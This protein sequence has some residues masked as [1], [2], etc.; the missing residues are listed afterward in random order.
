[1]GSYVLRLHHPGRR[2]VVYPVLIRRCAA[3]E[4]TV[5]LRTDEEIGPEFV[6]VPGGPFRYGRGRLHQVLTR[7]ERILS[8][9][10]CAVQARPVTYADYARFLE[11]V[12]REGGRAAVEARMPS[13]P[14]EGPHMERGPDGEYRVREGLPLPPAH[15]ANLGLHGPAYADRL[16]VFG[17]S[18]HDAR[19]YCAWRTRETGREW[20]LPTEAEWEK[21]ARG[22]DGR[23]YPWGD[24]DDRSL[25]KWGDSRP[26]PAFPE[27]VGAFPTATSVY[28][29]VDAAG[30]SWDWTDT[31]HD[32]RS[33]VQTIRGGG[34]WLESPMPLPFRFGMQPANRFLTFG[35]RCA[36]SL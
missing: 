27:P 36:R 21:A 4:A 2:E 31:P 25:A 7:P 20:R 28:G 24:S 18:F 32:G 3:W 30:S 8:L 22:V 33:D 23:L 17:V 34:S 16:P 6:Y 10:D 12:E 26:G 19:A 29:M 35:F 15:A 14:G 1:M 5:R 9:P 11:A 13:T